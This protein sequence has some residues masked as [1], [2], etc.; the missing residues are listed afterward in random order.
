MAGMA[1]PRKINS[2]S[3]NGLGLCSASLNTSA[4][5]LMMYEVRVD[6]KSMFINIVVDDLK[7]Y[8]K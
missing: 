7:K 3:P 6:A 1:S 5:N 8:Y 4:D 2:R